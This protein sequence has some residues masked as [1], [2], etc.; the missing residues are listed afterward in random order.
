MHEMSIAQS[1]LDIIKE[2]MFKNDAKVLK[3]V[4]LEVGQLSAVVPESLSFCFKVMV[5]GTEFEGAELI[6]EVIPLKGQCLDCNEIFEIKDYVF[7]CP[8][9]GSKEVHTLSGQDLKI[10]EMTVE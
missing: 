1:L 2:E 4:R 6:M 9:C 7:E 5:D 3:S 10:V 8:H